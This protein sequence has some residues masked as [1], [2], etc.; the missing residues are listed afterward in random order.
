MHKRWFVSLLATAC[1]PT[2]DTTRV[3]ADEGSFG[4]TVYTLAC[5]RVAHQSDLADGDEVVDVRG[6][7]Y[8][9]FCRTGADAPSPAYPAVLA[10]DDGR[11]P[12][13]RALDTTFPATDLAALQSYLTSND[14]LDVYDD[15]TAEA[16]V[17]RLAAMFAA[18]A[19]DPD[20]APALS[21]LEGRAGY[22]PLRP[23]L[24]ALRAV[25]DWE[26]LND[27]LL[28]LIDAITEGG[29]AR[30]EFERFQLAVARELMDTDIAPDR[31]APDRT[32]RLAVEMLL[33]ESPLLGTGKP[34]LLVRR[35][36][37][38]LAVV[39]PDPAT[40]ALPP[41]F[42][43]ADSDG[44]AD[45]DSQGRFVD[46][47][48]APL[49][50]AP[51]PFSTPYA[52]DT[53]VA[54]DS[55]DRALVDAG[56]R[57]VYA[58]IDL[59]RTVLAALA[60]DARTL[61]DPLRGTALDLLRGASALIGARQTTTHTYGD[62]STI[63]YRGYDTSSSALL[64]LLHGIL[65]LLRDPAIDDTL[66]LLRSLLV[67][68]EPEAARLFEAMFEV[69]DLGDQ[70]PEAVLGTSSALYDDLV[71]VVQE[72]LATPGLAEDLLRALEDPALRNLDDRFAEFMTYKD[73]LDYDPATQDI[74]GSLATP[75][76][77]AMDDDDWNRSLMQRL[78]HLIADSSGVE[79]CN[80]Q[81][82]V[83]RDPFFGFVIQSYDRCE[84]LQINDLAVFYVQSIAYLKDASGNV[85]YDDRG[86]PMPKAELP[87]EFNN[88][89]IESVL[90]DD[91]MEEESTID[92]FRS[93]P[94]PHA[95]NRVLL[96]DPA[97][98]FIQDTMDPAICKD[99][100]RFIDAHGGTLPVWELNGF[101]DQIRPIVQ[102]FADHD[103]EHLFVDLLVV[104][105]SHYPSRESVQ[106][107]SVNPSGH[108]YAKASNVRAW[109]PMM[110]DVLTGTDLWEAVTESAATLNTL[111]VP[112]GKTAPRA[113]ADAARYIFTPR[114]DLT[115]RL[116]ASSTVTAD[117]RPVDTLSP[118]Y[119]LADAY[120]LKRAVLAEAGAE[121][122]AWERAVGEV[123]DLLVRG[124][125]S[126]DVWRFRN[127]RFR[128][129][130]VASIDFL[131]GRLAAH[132]A[133]GDVDDWLAHDLPDR[134]EEI[135]SGPV[136]AGAADFV[137][138]LN[139]SPEARAALEQL[140]VY[141]TSEL[142]FDE[143]FQTCITVAADLLQLYLDDPDVVPIARF[144]GRVFDPAFGLVASHLAFVRQARHADQ[145]GTLHR[146]MRN[147]LA[148]ESEGRT[149]L[150]RIVDAICEVNR[151]NPYVD[152]G[153]PMSADDYRSTFRAVARFLFDERRSLRT[154]VDIVANR[155]AHE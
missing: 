98:A 80:K 135:L 147:L 95:L 70:H 101:Y 45:A 22:R 58:Y 97:P 53:A 61:F 60:R 2:L 65:G 3:P 28:V 146:L 21:R 124:E 118:W 72:I 66:G 126:G 37:R 47:T 51:P 107:Q 115:K 144:V 39:L 132:R 79:M 81:D 89:L 123:V 133:A 68:H 25:A 85:V 11:A 46:A 127:P 119:V 6:D 139:A 50:V 63:E 34:R 148:E 96:L 31:D 18:A 5:K 33:G 19:D 109:E 136:F 41:P 155:H 36:I 149:A 152:R 88:A 104:V 151:L 82:A 84:L 55:D 71:P 130:A 100:D 114:P 108:G 1:S 86:L 44:W 102:A 23:A 120:A 145:D 64:E 112:S 43:D 12:L 125:K 62:G 17:E 91:L 15:G 150:S 154:F 121:G 90:S 30:G 153:K 122:E 67:D 13:V 113:L 8:R 59:D 140:H 78:L 29:P 129:V 20:F 137:L 42:A 77:R 16:S 9:A 69:A 110:I 106:H 26:G 52:P 93:H 35:D 94:T 99:G 83:I 14:F 92:G 116:G 10:L 74:V 27:L 138:A 131:R 75:V 49:E 143:V 141:L 87:L 103:A 48:G 7:L 128:G 32:A 73:R 111:P 56:G 105:H 4:T 54:R 24:G 57:P 38:G 40:G 142:S 117:G 134:G 76:D